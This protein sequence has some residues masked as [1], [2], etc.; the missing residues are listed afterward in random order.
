[1]TQTEQSTHIYGDPLLAPPACET[2][3]AGPLSIVY[4]AD[5]DIRYIQYGEQE[6]IRRIYVAVRANDWWTVP[7]AIS[8]IEKSVE[9]DAFRIVMKPC[10]RHWSEGLIFAPGL[11]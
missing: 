11:H 8:V 1:M 7:A 10:I 5:G 4:T 6:L 2:L 3:F 9:K